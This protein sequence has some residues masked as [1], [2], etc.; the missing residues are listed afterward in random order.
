MPLAADL[1]ARVEADTRQGPLMILEHGIYLGVLRSFAS[2]VVS[3]AV[4]FRP[5]RRPLGQRLGAGARR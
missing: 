5:S 1:I 2:Q 3:D 4:G